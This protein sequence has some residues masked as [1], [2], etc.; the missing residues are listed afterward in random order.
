MKTVLQLTLPAFLFFILFL[1]IA[2]A[3][4]TLPPLQDN[5]APASFETMWSGFDPR[6]EPL[7]TE[8]V[9]EWEEDGVV[10]RIVRFRVGIFKGQKSILAAVY[11]FPKGA[12]QLPGLVQIHGG[13]Q[14][15]DYQA[16][17]T[18]AKRGYATVSIA[19]AGRISAPKYRV[20]AAEVKL[21][22]DGKTDD[23]NY[24]LTTDWGAVDG[25]HAPGRNPGNQFP[26]A[27][28]AAWTLDRVESPRNSGWF[29]AA[30]AARR[31]LT[32]LEQQPEVD[33]DRLGVYGHSMGGKLTVLSAVDPRVKAAAPSCGGISDR[34]NDS[35][36][37][38]ATLGDD[39]SL[40]QITCP[41]IFLSPA[42]DFHGRIGDLPA[43]ISELASQDWRVTCAPHHN[44]Q[45]TSEYE[46]ATQLWFDQHLKGSFE[47]P[48]TP[49]TVLNLQ[50]DDRIPVV[51]VT[52][53][54]AKPIRAVDVYYTQQGLPG[55]TPSDRDVT[56]HRFWH[57][58][59]SVQSDQTWTA[60][61]PVFDTQRPLWVYANVSYALDPPV[62]GAGYYY[63]SYTA[64]SFNV[65]SLLQTATPEDLQAADVRATLTP[66]LLIENF[67]DDWEKE[68][69]NYRPESWSWSTHKL[70]NPA[71]QGPP[72]ATLT[73]E[74]QAAQPN[75]F[76]VVADKYAAEVQLMGGPDW[77][78]V[79]LKRQDF[80]N[81]SGDVLPN[82]KSV[83]LLK[84]CP[85][86]RLTPNR[87]EELE[88]RIIGKN[89]RGPDPLFRDL[90]WRIAGPAA[91]A[92][93]NTSFLDLLPEPTFGIDAKNAGTT[94][95]VSEYSPSGSIWDERL[96]ETQVFQIE[97]Q[98]QQD[99]DRSFQLRIG[100]G[101]QIYSLRGAFGES[102]PPSW[103]AA[104]GHISPWNDEVWQ[105]VAVCTKYNGIEA[106]QKAGPVPARFADTLKNS[107]YRDTFFIHNSGAYI[108][109]D[110]ALQSLYCPLLDSESV[111]SQRCFRML[112]WGL[113][114]QIKTIH[115]SPLLYYTQVR[116]AGDGVIEMTWAIHNFSVRDDVVFDHLNAPWGGTRISSLPFRYVSS[117]EGKL[118]QREGFLSEHGTAPVRE[119][120]G[121]NISCQ[122][123][124]D[125]AP[126]L[127]LVYGRDKHLETERQ[128][129]AAGAPYCQFTHSLYRDWR[130][131]EPLYKT[132]WQD[133][134]TRPENSFRNYDVCEIIPKLRIEPG[135]TIWFRSYLVVGPKRKAIE[136][137]ERLVDHVDYGLLTFAP[138]DT[139]M[140]T[141]SPTVDDAAPF[142]V[143]TRPVAGSMPLFAIKEVK[144]GRRIIT[145]DP[146]YFVDQQPLNLS[147]P[148][149]H[150]HR[151][152]YSQAV[153]YTLD[154]NR[155]QWQSL[156]GFAY[157]EKPTTGRWQ[158]LSEL[159]DPKEFPAATLY[160][161]DLWVGSPIER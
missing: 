140:K 13:G 47:F 30:V 154:P 112:N 69:F 26:S 110:S 63:R 121:W 16:C 41:I 62:S 89:W 45:D 33:G 60:K 51:T 17:L 61:L 137:A 15:A 79:T 138:A 141:V 10:L 157:K 160:H 155:S 27:K 72:G 5:A 66:S 29:L 95:F 38:R 146:Y 119:T 11:G 75:K 23:A 40:K 18:N 14:F 144:T 49:G 108:P 133:W 67:A 109:G 92:P 48:Q 1:R 53:D 65:S 76:V 129:K 135:T 73:L 4:E 34:Y 149:Q 74:I 98:H 85:A 50:T 113:V 151:D 156:V 24:K 80:K 99:R 39:V 147:L 58:A 131:S 52:P 145:S 116:D 101:G 127:A 81:L 46:V 2:A 94:D 139:A 56:A 32:F 153:G 64:D 44:H 117:P 150:P 91:A 161:Q 84:L 70:H 130:A 93:G 102:V 21:F 54:L 35:P 158:R 136:M 3:Q 36:L 104:G 115:R 122:S 42:N 22:W 57:H 97:M 118:L 12:K 68:W 152:Y 43:A 106:S 103:R 8:T 59:T 7:E 125:D 120:G 159:L 19:W 55:E 111:P 128:R 134:A 100:K 88:A 114:P 126:S 90:R 86:E 28:P 142:Q 77:Q 78:T 143:L 37:F 132:Q 71:W 25:Y 87:G 105:F 31:A 20:S 83:M 124:A 96:D 82:W 148:E 6:A 123:E 107:G 9:Q